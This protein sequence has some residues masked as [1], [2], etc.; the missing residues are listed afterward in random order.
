MM[1]ALEMI[2]LFRLEPL[3]GE[4]GFFRQTYRSPDVLPPEAFCGPYGE[5]RCLATAIYYLLTPDVCSRLHRLPSDEIYH[6]YLGDPVTLLCLFPD[7][8]ADV[9]TLGQ[10]IR[11]GQQLQVV[12]PKGVWQGSLLGPDGAFALL[13]TTMAPGFRDQDYEAGERQALLAAYP[14]HGELIRALTA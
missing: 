4:G 6:F 10:D 7:G 9:V 12:V 5:S 11:K 2:D 13:G 8:M 14:E 1:T 3:G